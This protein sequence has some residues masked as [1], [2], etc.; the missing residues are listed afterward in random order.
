MTKRGEGW[1][2]ASTEEINRSLRGWVDPRHIYKQ[3]EE[4]WEKEDPTPPEPPKARKVSF[5]KDFF[6]AFCIYCRR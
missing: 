3:L 5:V 6:I 4:H 2:P 1:K